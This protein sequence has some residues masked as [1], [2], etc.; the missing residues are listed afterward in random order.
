MDI[1]YYGA[2]CV[3]LST[4]KSSVIVDDNLAELGLKSV[5]KSDDIALFTTVHAPSKVAKLEIDTPGEYEA[6][7]VSIRGIAARAHIDEEGQRNA[8]IYKIII[9][10]I[11]IAVVGHVHPDLS[12]DQLE[13]LGTVD[14]AIVPVGGAGYTLDPIGAVK[15]IKKISP[16]LVIPTHYADKAI[17][18]PV[19]QVELEEAIKGLSMEPNE[20]VDTLKLKTSEFTDTVQLAVLNRR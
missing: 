8:T 5:T 1:Q 4:K 6:S 18:Y 11:R 15:V 16:K 2:N 12:E 10:D 20:P 7:G 9:G 13:T 3:R 14:V 17:D 19:P